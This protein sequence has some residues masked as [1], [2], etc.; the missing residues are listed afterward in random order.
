MKKIITGFV[1]ILLATS[2]WANELYV[3]QIGDNLQLDITQTGSGNAI[4]TSI[5]D[6]VLEGDDMTFAITQVGNSNTIVATIKGDAYTGT[7]DFTGNSNA[8]DL[9]CSAA[10]T[11][12]CDAVTMVLTVNGDTNTFDFDIGNINDAISA[13]VTFTVDGDNNVIESSIN[14]ANAVLNVTVDN[15]ASLVAGGVSN[16]ATTLG[17]TALSA[18]GNGN[19]IDVE[20]NGDGSGVGHSVTL[21]ITGGGSTYNIIQDSSLT[22]QVINGTFVGDNQHVNIHQSN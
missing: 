1:F 8:I 6:M 20:Q 19:I 18:S 21:D 11:G 22:D 2:S 15:T 5:T 4:G 7:W 3:S 14:G 17:N 10:V 12:N 13:N 9:Q 16:S